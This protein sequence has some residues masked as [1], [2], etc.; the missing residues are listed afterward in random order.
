ME[1]TTTENAVSQQGSK[2]SSHAKRR[3]KKQQQKKDQEI[4]YRPKTAQPA[5]KEEEK[6]GGDKNIKPANPP[7]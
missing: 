6:V 5:Q 4:E 3:Q 2:V 7:K 1:T